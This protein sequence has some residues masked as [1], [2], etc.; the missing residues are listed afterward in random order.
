MQAYKKRAK[1]SWCQGKGYKG[2]S[3]ERQYSKDEIKQQLAQAEETYL[4][5]H[6]G[7]RKRNEK[8]RL[9]YRVKWYTDTLAR[10]GDNYGSSWCN[11][12]RSG[13]EQAKKDLAA[14]KDK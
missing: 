1:G 3:V 10:Y 12:L 6:K 9:E 11:Q 4:E 14:L 7:K 13:L 2:D 8:A 5:R